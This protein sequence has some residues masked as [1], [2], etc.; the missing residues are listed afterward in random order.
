MLLPCE[1]DLFVRIEF[2]FVSKNEKHYNVLC[3]IMQNITDGNSQ[4]MRDLA[5]FYEVGIEEYGIKQN[6]DKKNYWNYQA[7]VHGHAEAKYYY[8][9]YLLA[10][11]NEGEIQELSDKGTKY[12][13]E[14]ADL[15]C[16][17]AQQMVGIA[18][19]NGW[20]VEKS[21]SKALV[22]LQQAIDNGE[23]RAKEDLDMLLAQ[24]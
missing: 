9:N 5:I 13:L 7:A 17:R 21:Y 18:Y 2:G 10:N 23:L 11:S 3:Q 6:E 22:Y 14:A 16:A 12:V 20:G 15:G 24:R 1:L 19:M 4:T 8:G